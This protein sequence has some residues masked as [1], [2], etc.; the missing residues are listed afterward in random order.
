MKLNPFLVYPLS[1][2][3]PFN[4]CYFLYLSRDFQQGGKEK[5]VKTIIANMS[6][7]N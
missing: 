1:D 6:D 7:E 4:V 2:H 3:K 5:G